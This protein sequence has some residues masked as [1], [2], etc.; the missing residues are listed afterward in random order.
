[1]KIQASSDPFQ[2]FRHVYDVAAAGNIGDE[3][4]FVAAVDLLAQVA[5]VSFDGIGEHIAVSRPDMFHEEGAGKD[6]ADILHEVFEQT[7]LLMRHVD[8]SAAS[9]NQMPLGVEG[10]VVDR[11]QSI[12]AENRPASH[13]FE[14]LL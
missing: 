1:M 3:V 8:R 6:D 4:R 9:C 10:E 14:T 5:D 2:V 13:R 7:E 12:S 11:Q